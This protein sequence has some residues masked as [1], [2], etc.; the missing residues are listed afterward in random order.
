MRT[1]FTKMT[2]KRADAKT[3]LLEIKELFGGTHSELSA[4]FQMLK[5][6]L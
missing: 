5:R 3:L 1:Y 2:I 4:S 6:H